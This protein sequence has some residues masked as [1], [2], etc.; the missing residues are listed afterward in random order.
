MNHTERTLSTRQKATLDALADWYFK[1]GMTWDQAMTRAGVTD[2]ERYRLETW[3]YR[4]GVT[5]DQLRAAVES[6]VSQ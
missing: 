6:S 3:G 2:S 1:R 5:I 4:D